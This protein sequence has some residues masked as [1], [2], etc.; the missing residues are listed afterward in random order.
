MTALLALAVFAAAVTID[1]SH[2]RY[3]RAMIS[4][5]RYAAATWSV[6]QWS[7]AIVGFVIAVRHSMWVLPFE[8]AGLFV[9][10]LLG[11]ANQGRLR[12]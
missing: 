6:V 12:E 2:A 3:V 8:A 1:F 11:S 7:G 5:H 4:G 9:G 10:T